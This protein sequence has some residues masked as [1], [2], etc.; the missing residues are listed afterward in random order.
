M[1]AAGLSPSRAARRRK[2]RA[3]S[4]KG[5]SCAASG[6]PPKHS[7]ALDGPSWR[8]TCR[9][10]G[11]PPR[12]KTFAAQR[13]CRS[14]RRS[15]I[16]PPAWRPSA[17][18]ACRRQIRYDAAFGRPLDYYT[19][20]VF[21]ISSGDASAAAGGRR[22]LRPAADPARRKG[23]YPGR[24]LFGLARSY[25]AVAR[26]RSMTVTLAIPSKGRLKEQTL[27]MLARAGLGDQPARRRPQVSRPHRRPRRHRGRLSVGLGNRPRDRAGRC[28][29]RHHRRGSA[30]RD[31]RRLRARRPRS[32]PGWA[33]AGPTS[34]S[35]CRKAGSTS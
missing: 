21:E 18:K 25:R 3:T 27:D 19:G 22:P 15:G 8:S 4:S 16:S 32:Q 10:T 29:S 6:S 23:A 2:S 11:P 35:P 17:R 34:W 30:A 26:G 24:R 31:P 14:A 1:A 13:A 7:A 28:R 33:S 12:S 5:P 20:L 9:S